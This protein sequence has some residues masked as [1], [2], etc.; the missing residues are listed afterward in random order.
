MSK[1]Y[2]EVF[3]STEMALIQGCVVGGL[4][5]RWGN[6]IVGLQ[7]MGDRRFRALGDTGGSR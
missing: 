3:G 4:N 1:I 2:E 7:L 6:K 5:R